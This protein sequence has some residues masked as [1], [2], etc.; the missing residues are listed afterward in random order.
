MKLSSAINY[1][2]KLIG[3]A[4]NPFSAAAINHSPNLSANPE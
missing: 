4:V 1:L 3:V 2:R